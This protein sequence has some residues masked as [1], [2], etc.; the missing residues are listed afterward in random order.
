MNDINTKTHVE[1]DTIVDRFL[2]KV[3]ELG[4]QPALYHEVD[5]RWESISWAEY[6]QKA[7][8]FAGALIGSGYESEDAVAICGYNCP[9]W[10]IADVGAM[11]AGAVP[12]G[13][14]HTNTPPEVAYVA[15]HCEASVL[16]VENQEQW[17]KVDKK[18]DDIPQLERV[19]MIRDAEKT[20]DPMVVDFDDFLEEGREHLDEVEVRCQTIERDDVGTM[21]YTSG[22]TGKPKGVMLSHENLAFTASVTEEVVG[23]LEEGDNLV[24]Y[25]PLSHIA[26]Q[27]FTIHLALTFGYPVWFATDIYEVKDALVAARPTF[28]FGVPR[29]WEKFKSALETKLHEASGFKAALVDWCRKVGKEAGYELIENGELSGLLALKYKIADRLF[30]SK[31]KEQLGLDRLRIAI[32]SAAPIGLD[33]LE[34]FL[35]CDIIIREVYGQSE[36]T[37]PSTVNFPEPGRTK[38]GTVGLPMP[39]VEV[40]IDDGGIYEDKPDGE[41]MVRGKNVFEGYFKDEEATAESM[42]G[43]WLRSGDIGKRDEDG[44]LHITGRKKEIIITAGGKNIA[45][46]K[47]EGGLK[48]IDGIG[49]AVAIGDRRKYVTALMTL[50]PD[51]YPALAK[52]RGWPEDAEELIADEDFQSYIDEHVAKL[53]E[54][55]ASV[56]TVKKYTVLPEDFS[57]ETGELTP[58]QKVKRRVID[59]KYADEIDAMY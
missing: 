16:V 56:K 1:R 27:M 30:F 23:G 48:E 28:F 59:E 54:E 29:I 50:D 19:V 55:L 22:T 18:R 53:N 25:L 14:Y 5:G 10:V 33:V 39:Q 49:N 57:Q 34:F 40:K 11:V 47:I 46:Q 32:S 21:I 58:T 17:E 41:V 31:L 13:I 51:R 43:E 7:R 3:G 12:V 15:D 4:S 6:G 52:E 35:S 26:E 2:E 8:E 36:V 42:D 20:D 44:F 38:L 37:G 24:S 45:P 9:E